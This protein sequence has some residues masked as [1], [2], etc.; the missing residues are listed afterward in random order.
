MRL[1]LL[2]GVYGF[3]AGCLAALVLW[4]MALLSELIWSGPTERWYVFGVIM[5]GGLLIAGLRMINTGETLDQ[6]ISELRDPAQI[7]R[8]DAA[9]M[10]AMA[11]VAVSFGGCVGPEA[12]ILAVIGELGSLISIR[13]ARNAAEARL[14]SEAGA[15][16]ALGGLYGS[17]PAGTII[18][19]ESPEAPRWLLFLAAITGL[20]G[21]LLVLSR[22]APGQ[23]FHIS[24]P[25]HEAAGDGTDMVRALLP[26]V[27]GAAGGGSFVLMLPLLQS[28]L[29][30][31][32]GVVTQTLIGSALFAALAA[33]LPIL[34]F[35]GHHEFDAMLEWGQTSGMVAL[36]ALALFKAF[37]LAIC[38]ASGWRGGAM[39]PLMFVGAAAG[40][41]ALWLLPD[42]SPTVALVAG[43]TAAL[44]AGVGKP[45]VA[46]SVAALTIGV[47]AVGPLCVGL[48]VGWATALFLPRANL[49]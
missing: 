2:A 48:A 39:F 3:I 42:V 34:R 30:R 44:T 41:S 1:G 46:V 25:A 35:S 37:A 14:L 22:F 32:G 43:M 5:A 15:A 47:S 4:V 11:V 23:A 33:A 6:Q 27:L 29:K 26:A 18:A 38:L 13:L 21:F 17:P 12:G 49:H 7:K 19:Q 9:L 16:G 40:G 8:K 24:L 31:T 20:L 28:A 45:L 10:A 36:L